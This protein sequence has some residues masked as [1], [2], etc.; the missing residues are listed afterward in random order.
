ML[1][2]NIIKII[3]EVNMSKEQTLSIIKPDA[4][5]K[6]IIGSI[7]NRFETSGLAI[8]SAKM[9]HLTSEQVLEFYHKHQGKF[10]FDDLIKFMISGAVFVQILE[11]DF[12]IR[13]NREIIGATDPRNALAGTIRFDYGENCTKNAIHGSDSKQ[14]AVYEISFFFGM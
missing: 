12:A 6:N 14:S 1:F 4:V 3:I 7:I 13:R 10:F 2:F 8:V 11:G 5:F 9:M